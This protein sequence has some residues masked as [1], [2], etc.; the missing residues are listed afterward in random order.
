MQVLFYVCFGIGAGYT[1]LSLLLGEVLGGIDLD[2]DFDFDFDFGGAASPVKPVV[3]AAFLTVFGAIGI[4]LLNKFPAPLLLCLAGFGGLAV[5]Y[6]IQRFIITP[7]YR[8]QNTSAVDQ[9]SLIG[10]SAT[11]TEAIP[12]GAYGKITY[13]AAGN[14]YTAPA[15]SED[16]SAIPRHSAVEIVYIKKNTYYVRKRPEE[17]VM[18]PVDEISGN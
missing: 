16:G 7:L 8:A 12:Q 6:A 11:V 18:P 10:G 4:L 5:A 2:F 3:I 17:Y 13:H 9:A 14:T 1:V 15:K